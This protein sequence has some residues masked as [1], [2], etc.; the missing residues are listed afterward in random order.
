M[1]IVLFIF[2][3]ATEN[4]ERSRNIH[5]TPQYTNKYSIHYTRI[6]SSFE[7]NKTLC[8]VCIWSSIIKMKIFPKVIW[9]II[10]KYRLDMELL[11]SSPQPIQCEN[12]VMGCDF[13]YPLARDWDCETFLLNRFTELMLGDIHNSHTMENYVKMFVH[14][15]LNSL[16]EY[17]VAKNIYKERND[18]WGVK[19][20]DAPHN[21][22]YTTACIIHDYVL[23]RDTNNF[24]RRLMELSNDT[25]TNTLI[26]T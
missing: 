7:D 18:I 25:T 10:E 21:W 16:E 8:V 11:E 15:P 4:K 17:M 2:T 23:S 3:N 19:T 20:N 5:V 14:M 24:I 12:T 9:E 13:L 6:Q 22:Y 1:R 26:I